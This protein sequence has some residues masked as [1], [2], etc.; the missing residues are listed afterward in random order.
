MSVIVNVPYFYTMPMD[1]FDVML[2]YVESMPDEVKWDRVTYG[3]GDPLYLVFN[4]V[5]EA[6]LFKLK[7]G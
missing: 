5:E 6:I 3:T 1:D 4:T 2:K 7:F